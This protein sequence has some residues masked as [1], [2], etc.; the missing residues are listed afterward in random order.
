MAHRGNWNVF[1]DKV[2]VLKV[3]FCMQGAEKDFKFLGLS[4]W[5]LSLTRLNS[6]VSLLIGERDL[7]SVLLLED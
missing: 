6:V 1:H 5:N 4:A 3:W 7:L 2:S